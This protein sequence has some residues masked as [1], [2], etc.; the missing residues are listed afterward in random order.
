MEQRKSDKLYMLIML[1]VGILGSVI[2]ILVG[3]WVAGAMGIAQAE[4]ISVWNGFNRVLGNPFSAYFNNYTPIIMILAFIVFETLYFLFLVYIRKSEKNHSSSNA[5]EIGTLDVT[6]Q[7]NVDEMDMFGD[8]LNDN[9]SFT[10]QQADLEIAGNIGVIIPDNEVS[11]QDDMSIEQ[12]SEP[13]VREAVFSDDIAVELLD[14][15]DM[16]Q[17]TAM[18]NL[19]KYMDV[20]VALLRGMFKPSMDAKEISEFISLFYE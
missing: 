14:E 5:E 6:A 2:F 19:T 10:D 17:I 20:D 1:F 3:Y 13:V 11:T 12:P 8:L 4:K 16:D 15:Y 7:E 18:L 9:N